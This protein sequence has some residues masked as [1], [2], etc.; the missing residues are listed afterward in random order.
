MISFN[1][2]RFRSIVEERGLK[3]NWIAERAGI[4]R[5]FLQLIISGER[6]P[7]DDTLKAIAKA[8][9]VRHKELINEK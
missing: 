4:T 7:S 2:K 8:I 1:V 5:Q 6:N 3:H 9:N